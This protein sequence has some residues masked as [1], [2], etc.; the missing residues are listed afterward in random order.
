MERGKLIW[1]KRNCLKVNIE[2][3]SSAYPDHFRI[4]SLS[5]RNISLWSNL[6]IEQC[7]FGEYLRQIWFLFVY[8]FSFFCCCCCC[9]CQN[10]FKRSR[11]IPHR[12]IEK[13]LI[14][15]NTCFHKNV[16]IFFQFHYH[17][18]KGMDKSWIWCFT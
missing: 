11:C 12:K 17:I 3:F 9:C 1:Q 16:S 18:I 10:F 13:L 6:L 4:H 8:L 14:C 2:S 7:Y 5:Q 15:Y